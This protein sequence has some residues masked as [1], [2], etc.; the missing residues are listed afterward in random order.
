MLKV[1]ICTPILIAIIYGMKS[2]IYWV[3]DYSFI[4]AMVLCLAIFVASYLT[5]LAIDRSRLDRR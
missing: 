1:I 5:A 2:F 3:A 4:G